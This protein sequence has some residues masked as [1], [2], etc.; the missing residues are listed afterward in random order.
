MGEEGG[1][2]Y[3]FGDQLQ[4][5]CRPCNYVYLSEE[6]KKKNKKKERRR[7]KEEEGKKK[8]RSVSRDIKGKKMNKV[9]RENEVATEYVRTISG[10]ITRVLVV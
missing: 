5:S 7:G 1:A 4:L 8:E 3:Y 2:G 6:G 10:K 9:R